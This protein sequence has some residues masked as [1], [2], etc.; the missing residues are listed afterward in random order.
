MS[1]GALALACGS[2]ALALALRRRGLDAGLPPMLKSDSTLF[3]P[4]QFTTWKCYERSL[5]EDSDDD[6][7]IAMRTPARVNRRSPRRCRR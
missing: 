7:L 2:V 3:A 6:P 1:G 4:F 5:V